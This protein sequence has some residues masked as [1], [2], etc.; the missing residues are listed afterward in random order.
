MQH[1]ARSVL[2]ELL[3]ANKDVSDRIRAD[4]MR[5]VGLIEERDV[6]DFR[7]HEL[8]EIADHLSVCTDL[9]DLSYHMWSLTTSLGFQ[10]FAIFVLS[11]GPGMSFKP[12]IC[13]SFNQK[14]IDRYVERRYQYVD[15]VMA[16]ASKSDGSFLFSEAF[17]N[18]PMAV[19]FWADAKAHRIGQQGVCFAMTRPNG[20]RIG[21]SFS[22]DATEEKISETVL[23]NEYDLSFL[24]QLAADSFCFSAA[25]PSLPNDTLS[26]NEL[27]FLQVLANSPD[28]KEALNVSSSFGSNESLQASIR[29]KLNVETVFQ[30]IAI[31]ASRGWFDD[32]PYDSMEILKPFSPLLG[33]DEKTGEMDGCLIE[34]GQSSDKRGGRGIK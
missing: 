25:G 31:A 9:S 7:T 32:L 3:W 30:A 27:R 1:W 14:W 11:Q 6:H 34:S 28:P 16:K 2:E 18:A 20:S 8:S 29:S 17:S 5:I 23:L 33:L 13:T 4:T 19:E 15:P 10:H 26:V 22:A 12:R 24:A 21:I